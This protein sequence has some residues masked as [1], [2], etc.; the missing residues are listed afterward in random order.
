MSKAS[1]QNLADLEAKAAEAKM[2]AE[3]ATSPDVRHEKKRL[4]LEIEQAANR[5]RNKLRSADHD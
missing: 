2:I 5:E 1:R 3:L 4:A